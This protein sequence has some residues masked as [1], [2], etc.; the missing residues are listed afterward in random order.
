MS[1]DSTEVGKKYWQANLRLMAFCLAV[2]AF[3]SFGLGVVFRPFLSEFKIG[4]TDL[5]FWI[6]QQGAIYVFV[7]LIFFYAFMMNRLDKKYGVEED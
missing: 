1:N 3:V 4:G 5:G 7:I 2:W 6:G